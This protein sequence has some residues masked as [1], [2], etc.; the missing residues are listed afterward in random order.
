MTPRNPNPGH[1]VW[2]DLEMTGL[3]ESHV[4]LEIATVVTDRHLEIIEEGPALAIHR[5]H[6]DLSAMDDWSERQHTES[7][8]LDRV[9]ASDVD[10]R[11]AERR[12]LDFVKQHVAIHQAPLCGNSIWVDRMFLR[13]EMPKLEGYLHY[14]VIDVSTIKELY[15]RWYPGS[16]GAPLKEQAHLALTD[17]RE[18]IQELRWYRDNCF[19]DSESLTATVA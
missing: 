5:G 10:V 1:L 18:S 2:I 15:S 16:R 19:V 4:I 14:R 8:L 17:I 3:Q 9:L 11:E 6:D 12:T 7:G 13:R